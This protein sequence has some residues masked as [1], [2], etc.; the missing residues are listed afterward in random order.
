MVNAALLVIERPAEVAAKPVP[1]P[2]RFTSQ[3]D[4]FAAE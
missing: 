3:I 2:V 4:L 1:A